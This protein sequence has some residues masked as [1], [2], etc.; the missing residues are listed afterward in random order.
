MLRTCGSNDTGQLGLPWVI[1]QA[2]K[3]AP[4]KVEMKDLYAA[5]H[6]SALA[7][8][9]KLMAL[10]RRE[11]REDQ[12]GIDLAVE[13]W[14]EVGGSPEKEKEDGAALDPK[15]PSGAAPPNVS[16]RGRP[17]GWYPVSRN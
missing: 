5:E 11:R 7:K 1:D 3:W 6:A 13:I 10:R 2:D 17:P 15:P 16:P 12:K 9:A 14:G 4:T 8:A